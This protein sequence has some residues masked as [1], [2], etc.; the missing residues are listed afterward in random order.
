MA[1]TMDFSVIEDAV[2]DLDIPILPDAYGWIADDAGY[3]F[4]TR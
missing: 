1:I 3:S 2:T 4:L